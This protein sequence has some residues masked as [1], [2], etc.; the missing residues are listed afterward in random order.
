MLFGGTPY[1]PDAGKYFAY[2]FYSKKVLNLK[3]L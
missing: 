3:V 1:H 2:Q